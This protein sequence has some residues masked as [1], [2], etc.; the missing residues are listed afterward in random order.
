MNKELMLVAFM[1]WL[2]KIGYRGV[3]KADGSITFYCPVVNQRFPRNV[4]IGYDKKLN[5]VARALFKEFKNHL[6]S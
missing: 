4:I 6:E 1:S 3:S 5:K 2:I